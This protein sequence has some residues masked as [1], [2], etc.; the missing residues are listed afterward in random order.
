MKS[1]SELIAESNLIE[2]I[3]R[4]VSR[5]E[6]VAFERFLDL[7]EVRVSDLVHFVSVYQPGAI[8]RDRPGLNV[9]VGIHCPPAGG[10]V[11]AQRLDDL[12][13]QVNQ[14]KLSPWAAHVRYEAL[15]PFTD[16]NGRSGRMLWYWMH[17]GNP[18][19]FQY[20]FLH[21]FYYE[22]LQNSKA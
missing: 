21:W 8:L 19:A 12:L 20:G 1:H 2:G 22:S 11:I 10:V 3:N 16:G 4:P 7:E 14:Q 13:T 5:E 15:H 9:R 18:R 6:V 17:L